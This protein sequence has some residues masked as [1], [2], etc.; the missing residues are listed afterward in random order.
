[1]AAPAGRE[2][3]LDPRDR[4]LAALT[5]DLDSGF[6]ELFAAY[7]RV[8]FS[9]ALRLCGKFADAEDLAAE[10]FLRAYRALRGYDRDRTTS[11]QPRPWLLTIL[12]NLWRNSL[13]TA[14]R[15]PDLVAEVPE[16]AD[17]GE[18]VEQAVQRR[19][20]GR[21]LAALLA[22]LPP[23]QRAAVVLRHVSDLP[24]AE[25]AAILRRPQGT[26]KSH[27]S[28]GLRRLRELQPSDYAAPVEVPDDDR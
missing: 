6:A 12:L 16:V 25:I 9:T 15:Q 21:E 20:T 28:R 13:R 5:D 24:V 8:V 11:L 17:P 27:I 26:V 3:A 2:A 1:M 14:A 19:E 22:T 23:E 7:R 18:G 4:V 10:T